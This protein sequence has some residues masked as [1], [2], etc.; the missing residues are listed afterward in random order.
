MISRRFSTPNLLLI[1]WECCSVYYTTQSFFVFLENKEEFI[2]TRLTEKQCRNIRLCRHFSTCFYTLR[3]YYGWR[4]QSSAYRCEC[5]RHIP[6]KSTW[7][8]VDNVAPAQATLRADLLRSPFV[9]IV[10]LKLHNRR[11]LNSPFITRTKRRR[12]EIF[13]EILFRI[14]GN[15]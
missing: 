9:S 3:T 14:S 8:V 11:H 7:I 13:K 10:P 15:S 2:S 5:P 12:L 4:R 1:Y 6:G